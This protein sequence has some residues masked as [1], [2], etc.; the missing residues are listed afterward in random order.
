MIQLWRVE[1]SVLS[2]FWFCSSWFW[3]PVVTLQDCLAAF[4][5]RDELKGKK[6]GVCF[7]EY[8]RRLWVLIVCVTGGA[9]W[10]VLP[11]RRPVVAALFSFLWGL[12]KCH[13]VLNT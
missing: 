4:F 5:A 9:I 11:V 6:T 1:F 3:G 2:G 8:R 7:N 12:I 13:L 10:L